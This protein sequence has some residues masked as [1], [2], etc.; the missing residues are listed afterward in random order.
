MGNIPKGANPFCYLPAGLIRFTPGKTVRMIATYYFPTFRFTVHTHNLVPVYRRI[1]I[2]AAL[3]TENSGR[4]NYPD[5]VL[6]NFMNFLLR[7]AKLPKEII[8]KVYN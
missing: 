7:M 5:G 2:H 1:N 4:L 8:K 6:Q 3:K